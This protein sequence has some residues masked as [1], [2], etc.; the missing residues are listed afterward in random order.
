M[1]DDD[2]ATHCSEVERTWWRDHGEHLRAWLRERVEEGLECAHEAEE[3]KYGAT[4]LLHAIA[5]RA[6]GTLSDRTSRPAF[7][8]DEVDAYEILF[9]F[10]AHVGV[11]QGWDE[12]VVVE[13]I[14]SFADY[15]GRQ[16]VI[17]GP[18]H[19]RL[20]AE[21]ELW[22]P[23]ILDFFDNGT[24]YTPKGTPMRHSG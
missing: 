3:A 16:G 20:Q 18:T 14:R 1:A 5:M 11:M 6:V 15:L 19:E 7:S 10:L 21:L 8:W 13:G 17:E 4:T 23:R 2:G 9:D 24:W 12:E 22:I